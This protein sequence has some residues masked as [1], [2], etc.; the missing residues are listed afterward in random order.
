MHNKIFNSKNLETEIITGKQSETFQTITNI[1][2][3]DYYFAQTK[4]S[5]EEE[6]AELRVEIGE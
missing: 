5:L 6:L 4:E 3:W 2:D 1:S